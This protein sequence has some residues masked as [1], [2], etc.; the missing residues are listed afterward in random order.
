MKYFSCLCS[1]NHCFFVPL[2]ELR[3][4]CPRGCTCFHFICV[5]RVKVEV[6]YL[7]LKICLFESY[8][9]LYPPKGSAKAGPM[10]SNWFSYGL[11]SLVTSELKLEF[12]FFPGNP[13]KKFEK[14]TLY[15]ADGRMDGTS[16][17]SF[18]FPQIQVC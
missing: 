10:G 7:C 15:C 1:W 14:K 4:Q 11:L 18:D 16:K 12:Q 17:E 2:R 5:W 13:P 3:M 9:N 8:K 6:F